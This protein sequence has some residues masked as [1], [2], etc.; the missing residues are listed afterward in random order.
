MLAE[1]FV[2]RTTDEWCAVLTAAGQRFA[3]VRDY[4]AVVR[5]PQT[6]ANGYFARDGDGDDATTIV[7]TPIAL[8]DTPATPGGPPPELGAD[9]DA[10]LSAAGFTDDEIIGL[11]A[12][13]AI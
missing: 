1:V 6:W 4:A 8:S 3:P 7:G 2:T 12:S 11:R 13:G 9:T 10:V 5:D